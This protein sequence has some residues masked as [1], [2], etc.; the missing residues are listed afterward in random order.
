MKNVIK[1]IDM[2]KKTKLKENASAGATSAGAVASVSTGLN[3]PLLRRMPPTNFF[4]YKVVE[5][6]NKDKE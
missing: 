3:Y 5:T 1:G 2:K 6:K 4:G